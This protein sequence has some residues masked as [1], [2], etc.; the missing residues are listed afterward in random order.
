MRIMIEQRSMKTARAVLLAAACSC[1]VSVSASIVYDNSSS[2]LNRSYSPGNG[3]EFGDEVFLAGTD[4]VITLFSFETFV[5][6]NADNNQTAQVFLRLNDGLEISAGRRAPGTILATSPL[7]Q[8]GLKGKDIPENHVWDG[9]TVPVGADSLTWSIVMN[10]IDSGEQVGLA[11]YNPPTTGSSY[12]DIWQNTGTW[13]TFTFSTGDVANF[14][15]RITAV[16]VPEPSTIA[17]ATV[18]GAALLGMLIRRRRP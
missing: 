4:R 17:L 6:S 14:G 12:N 11:L 10:G 9:L 13:D 3:V 15:A 18:G 2:S 5:S 1:A 8:L 16:A 7:F